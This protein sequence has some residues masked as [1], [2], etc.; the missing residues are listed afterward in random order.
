MNKNIKTITKYTFKEHFFPYFP[1]KTVANL[2]KNYLFRLLLILYSYLV[3]GGLYYFVMKIAGKAYFASG[4]I[5]MFFTSFGILTSLIV[6]SLYG[7]RIMGDFF[8]DKLVANYQ[9][10]P[11]SQGEL[12]VGKIFGGVLGFIDYFFFFILTLLVYFGE[13]SLDLPTLILGLVNF[14]P[15][16]ASTYTMLAL[17]ILLIKRFTSANK[18]KKF[19]KNLGYLLMF[20]IIGMIYYLSFNAGN[21]VGSGRGGLTG[22]LSES[23]IKLGKVSTI[24]LNAKLF[25]LSLSGSIGQRLG[26]SLGL[27]LMAGLIIYISYK[28]ADKC[29]YQAVFDKMEAKIGQEN[30]K[31]VRKTSFKS[32]SQFKAIYK[33]DLKILTS[34]IMF[35]YTPMLMLMIF[36]M[37]S[38]SVGKQILTEMD[39]SM[40]YAPWTRIMCLAGA[41]PFG[42]IVWINGSTATNALSRE[43]K[44]FYLF[45]T[46]PIDYKSH[47]RARFMAAMTVATITNLVLALLVGYFLGLGLVN[48]LCIFGGLFLASL[49]GTIV[50]LYLSTLGIKTDWKNPKDL[51]QGNL[52]FLGFYFLSMIF[53]GLLVG[54]FI[55]LA[56][57]TEGNVIIASLGCYCLILG[58]SLIFYLLARRKYKKG[59]F[60]V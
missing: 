25:G 34:N 56:K 2:P 35:L 26:A 40:L 10:L 13:N 33:R 30:P 60:D 3:F 51:S 37:M 22:G 24:F 58:L 43:G 41:F 4:Q 23:L 28:L 12:F 48:S 59:F 42:L 54:L 39:K 50:G 8:A 14:F 52:K 31:K 49:S 7:P 27:W 38:F 36:G 46:M 6:I 17:L 19:F 47:M 1:K 29:Y 20:A 53:I 55:L 5:E 45:Q 16:L 44:G 18:Y 57:L 9:S 15:M 32:S 21:M 11:I